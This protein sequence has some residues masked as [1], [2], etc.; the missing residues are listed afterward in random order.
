MILANFF[1]KPIP[2]YRFFLS[3][4]P[5]VRIASSEKDS[6]IS[7]L[8]NNDISQNTNRPQKIAKH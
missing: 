2:T 5:I 1:P 4:M 8:V 3:I 6:P 7:I